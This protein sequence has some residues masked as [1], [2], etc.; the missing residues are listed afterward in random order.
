MYRMVLSIG[1]FLV[2]PA[3]PVFSQSAVSDDNNVQLM[4]RLDEILLKL[5]RI[6]ARISKLEGKIRVG[7]EL[8]LD[9]N[10]ILWN[11]GGDAIGF[12]GIDEQNADFIK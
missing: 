9:R 11:P 4:K 5:E 12:W 7:N 3:I 1:L 2:I 6:E 10:S 8:W